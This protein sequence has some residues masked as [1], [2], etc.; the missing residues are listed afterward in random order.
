MDKVESEEPSKTQLKK[1]ADKLYDL[2]ASLVKLPNSVLRNFSLPD[3]LA[4][5]IKLAKSIKQNRAI[6]RQMQLVAKILR[7]QDT[8]QIE[9]DFSNYSLQINQTKK[10]F[11]AHEKW[12]D[13][14]LSDDSSVF[15]EFLIKYPSV[16]RQH[17]GQLQ[18]NALTEKKQEKPPKYARLLFK[19]IKDSLENSD[20]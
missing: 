19:Y 4:D 2:G 15:S 14:F 20:D 3:N 12:R 6:K 16:D 18:R 8:T 13:R 5:A 10:E 11:H 17:L 9:K 1:E 7:Q